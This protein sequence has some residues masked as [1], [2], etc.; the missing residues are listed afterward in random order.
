[1]NTST[2]SE[3][4]VMVALPGFCRRS[5]KYSLGSAS[6]SSVSGMVRVWL[7]VAPAGKVSVWTAG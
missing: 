5:E 2:S 6:R 3:P 7:A 1:M 4:A